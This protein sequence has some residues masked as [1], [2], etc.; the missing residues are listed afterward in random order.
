MAL[1]DFLA[2][3]ESVSFPGGSFDV[4][5]INLGTITMIVSNDMERLKA[6]YDLA[7]SAGVTKNPDMIQVTKFL[8]E[9]APD[10]LAK[11]IAY[12][13]GEPNAAVTAA[14]LPV[15]VQLDALNKIVGLTFEA[16]GGVKKFGE[17]LMALV[18]Q[19]TEGLTAANESTRSKPLS[20]DYIGSARS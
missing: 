11:I 14:K 12:S 3:T 10:I 2:R 6:L 20:E 17:T 7:E 8:V 1:K 4:G 18:A 16:E 13:S 9:N 5:A 19:L 15:G